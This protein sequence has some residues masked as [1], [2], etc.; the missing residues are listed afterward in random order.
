MT[1]S[2]YSPHGSSQRARAAHQRD[3][4]LGVVAS[5]LRLATHVLVPMAPTGI[6]YSRLA[7]VQEV[8]DDATGLRA[9]PVPEL[10][11][12]HRLRGAAPSSV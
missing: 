3:S 5:A 1:A 6:E 11:V 9:G 10:A 7:T 8:L 12:V 4:A 2:R